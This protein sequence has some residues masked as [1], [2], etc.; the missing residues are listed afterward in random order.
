MMSDFPHRFSEQPP[1]IVSAHDT[2]TQNPRFGNYIGGAVEEEDEGPQEESH[3]ADAYVDYD[4]EDDAATGQ[5][6]MEVDGMAI[7]KSHKDTV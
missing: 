5:E 2:N 4:E 1:V 7:Q 3:G 6:L